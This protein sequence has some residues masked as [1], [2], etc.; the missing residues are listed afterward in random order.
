MSELFSVNYRSASASY[1]ELRRKLLFDRRHRVTLLS[2]FPSAA[3]SA[4]KAATRRLRTGDAIHGTCAN[5]WLV[6]GTAIRALSNVQLT[7]TMNKIISAG[8]IGAFA[9]DTTGWEAYKYTYVID[10]QE[11]RV[12]TPDTRID[13]VS[14]SWTRLM[15]A[16]PAIS[17]K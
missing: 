9:D 12:M 15:D 5:T 1:W 10:G 4:K 11:V 2:T 7:N 17:I 6:A 8:C 14:I 16:L 13:G 3:R